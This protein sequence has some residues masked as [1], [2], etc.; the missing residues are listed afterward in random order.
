MGINVDAVAVLEVNSVSKI[1]LTI[2]INT[3]KII[4]IFDM[5]LLRDPIHVA[6]PDELIT[7][8]RD[9]PPPININAP[10]GIFW[11]TSQLINLFLLGLLDGIINKIIAAV[12]AIVESFSAPDGMMP[13]SVF[14]SHF[15]DIHKEAV[16][17]NIIPTI[18]SS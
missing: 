7:E 18:I 15:L 2:L 8:A 6:K 13:S 16:V 11:A 12:I 4:E 1:I 10:Q 17:I 3:I 14:E 9:N 5:L